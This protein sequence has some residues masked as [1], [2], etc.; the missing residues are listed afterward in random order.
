VS[1]LDTVSKGHRRA[2]HGAAVF[3]LR[4]VGLGKAELGA[5]DVHHRCIV[6]RAG[7]AAQP[8]SSHCL[9]CKIAGGSGSALDNE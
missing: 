1:S 8:E 9:S 7:L 6:A 3:F 5:R 2:G 4:L